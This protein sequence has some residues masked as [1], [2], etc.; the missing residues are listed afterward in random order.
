ML[1]R[2]VP[3]PEDPNFAA[4]YGKLGELDARMLIVEDHLKGVEERLKPLEDIRA[5][6]QGMAEDQKAATDAILKIA[7]FVPEVEQIPARLARLEA[8][9]FPSKH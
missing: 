3:A 1:P 5:L 6:L 7:R 8:A 4:I 9:V 2:I